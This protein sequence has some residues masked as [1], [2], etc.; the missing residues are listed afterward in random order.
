MDKEAGQEEEEEEKD[1]VFLKLYSWY[2][3]YFPYY[4]NYFGRPLRLNKSMYGMP[5]SGKLFFDEL[6]KLDNRQSRLYIVT[7]SN[8]YILKI[9]T[10]WKKLFCF[11]LF[12]YLCLFVFIWS[13]WKIVCWHSWKYIIC[14]LSGIF[15][16]VYVNKDFTA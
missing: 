4:A 5:N 10:R 3:E 14:E 16:L 12:W 15:T 6:I 1:I 11:I 9:C 7:L 8:L 2:G 13:S